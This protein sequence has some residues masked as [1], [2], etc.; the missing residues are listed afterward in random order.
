MLRIRDRFVSRLHSVAQLVQAFLDHMRLHQGGLQ[1]N[2]HHQQKDQGAFHAAIIGDEKGPKPHGGIEAWD[3][4]VVACRLRMGVPVVD[5]RK[6]R[7]A[8]VHRRMLVG[9][10]VRLIAIPV[11]V[12]TVLVVRIVAVLVRMG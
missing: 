1:G 12:V 2:P 10:C 9:V 5:I 4:K 11:K 3:A 7:M 6:V 8:V